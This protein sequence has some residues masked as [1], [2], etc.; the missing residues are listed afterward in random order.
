MIKVT[1]ENGYH[2]TKYQKKV[3]QNFVLDMAKNWALQ[4]NYTKQEIDKMLN[5]MKSGDR[6]NMFNVLLYHFDE[7]LIVK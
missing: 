4:R 3:G 1:L 5:K 6:Q 2:D 7:F